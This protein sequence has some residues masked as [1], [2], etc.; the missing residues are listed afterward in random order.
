MPSGVDAIYIEIFDEVRQIF[1][2]SKRH[3]VHEIVLLSSLI[4]T[5]RFI[6]NL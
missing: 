6:D 4:V 5:L 3:F 2:Y 1:L